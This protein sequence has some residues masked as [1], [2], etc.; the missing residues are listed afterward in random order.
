MQVWESYGSL[1]DPETRAAFLHTL[2]SVVDQSGQRVSATNRLY[3]ASRVPTMIVWGDRDLIIPV[4]QGHAAHEAIP[5]SRL[6][7]FEGA[8]HFP[9]CEQPERF[10]KVLTDFMTTTSA[11]QLSLAQFRELLQAAGK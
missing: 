10:V 9:H 8:G 1:A 6:E 4:H 11:A 3:L 2:R 7:I 5:G